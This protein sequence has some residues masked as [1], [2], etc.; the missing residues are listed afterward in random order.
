VTVYR[1]RVKWRFDFWK[2]GIRHRESGF[3]TKQEARAAEAE[4][5]KNLKSMNSDFIGLCVS[6]LKDLKQRRTK[7]YLDEN[8]WLIEKLIVRWK[9]KKKITRE[10][11]EEYIAELA[12]RSNN[13][14]NRDLRMIKALFSHG[15][16]RE[17]CDN[18]AGKIKFYPVKRKKKYIPPKA[19]VEKVLASARPRERNY[20]LAIINSLARVGEINKLK[21]EDDFPEYI[22]LRT[23]KSK[24][25]DIVE[26]KIPKN[27]TLKKAIKVMPKVGE[28]IFCYKTTGKPYRY[29]SKLIN[30][31]CDKA[32]VK[33]FAYHALRHYGASKLAE[34][35][36]ALTDI[37]YLLGHQRA[38]TTD[39]YLQS[40]SES[41]K[42]AMKNLE[43][44]TKVTHSK[45]RKSGKA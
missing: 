38:S 6:R 10:D 1:H 31:L 41:L 2:N 44:P 25:S 30:S 18:P 39:I 7:Q 43:S 27:A 9:N 42:D 5:R 3:S 23:K 24:N 36:V 40:I 20:L 45:K 28:Y 4:A 15:E 33:R 26:R 34:A 22:V 35:G 12:E 17:L 14:A 29:R 16:D 37:Q 11:V 32:K 19:D 13:L 8:Q 21:W